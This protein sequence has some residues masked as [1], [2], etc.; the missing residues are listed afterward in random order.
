MVDTGYN[1]DSASTVFDHRHKLVGGIEIDIN[2]E[3]V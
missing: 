1:R 3:E 2:F